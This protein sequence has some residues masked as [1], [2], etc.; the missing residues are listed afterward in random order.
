MKQNAIEKA[1]YQAQL[2][3]SNEKIKHLTQQNI[4]YEKTN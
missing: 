2:D 4:K 3:N 1:Q